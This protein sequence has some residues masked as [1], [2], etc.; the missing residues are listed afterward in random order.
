MDMPPAGWYPDPYGA[1]GLLR[2][3]DGATWTQHTHQGSTPELADPGPA[4]SLDATRIGAQPLTAGP[5]SRGADGF[6]P[7]LPH[8][9]PQ[10]T[11]VQPPVRPGEVTLADSTAIQAPVAQTGSS[12]PN[13]GPGGTSSSWPHGGPPGAGTD[14]YAETEH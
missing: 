11:T 5:G 2:W 14:P 7:A 6:R 12:W 13:A 10:P 9:V 1:P 3:W 4:T 8:A